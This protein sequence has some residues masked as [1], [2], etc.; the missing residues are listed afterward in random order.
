MISLQPK[1]RKLLLTS[2]AT[3]V[4]L[5]GHRETWVQ[6]ISGS[7]IVENP[8]ASEDSLDE[9]VINLIAETG[10]HLDQSNPFADVTIDAGEID[11]VDQ[12]RISG[13]RVHAALASAC[14][15]KTL[16]SIRIHGREALDLVDLKKQEMFNERTYKQLLEI[17][18]QAANFIISG[19]TGSGKTTLLR[20]MMFEAEQDRVIAIEDVAELN[21]GND[22]FLSLQ[23][24]QANIEQRGEVSLDRLLREALRMRPDRLLVGE[25]RGAEL[26]TMLQALNTGHRGS[27]TT[28]HANSMQAVPTRLLGIAAASGLDANQVAS[29]IA[30]AFDF[31]IH[32]EA[33]GE[34]RR[35]KSIGRIEFDGEKLEVLPIAPRARAKV[36]RVA[37]A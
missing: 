25:V 28:V 29:Q 21:L 11:G 31:V 5:N 6:S 10:R 37:A 20:A 34:G 19:A 33:V 8:F 30:E 23:T 27:A 13:L 35:L 15:S 26:I 4:F 12:N 17:V 16:V 22:F 7:Q 36:E 9:F 32:L 2:G 14:S 24:R 18:D 3:D 1:L